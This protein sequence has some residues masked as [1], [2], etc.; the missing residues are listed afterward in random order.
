MLRFC[1][2]FICF[3]FIETLFAQNDTI[4]VTDTVVVD[5]IF[6][7]VDTI[8]TV[9]PQKEIFAFPRKFSAIG[10][11]YSFLISHYY[12]QRIYNGFD[13]SAL[14][15]YTYSQNNL[16][17]QTGL[18]VGLKSYEFNYSFDETVINKSN[19]SQIDSSV[20]YQVIGKDTVSYAATDEHTKTIRDTITN[21]RSATITRQSIYLIVPLKCGI[22]RCRK[23]YMFDV[24][25]GVNSKILF[26]EFANNKSV[27][28]YGKIESLS[29][30]RFLL[31]ALVQ[32]GFG[33]AIVP[34]LFANIS[35]T[36]YLPIITDISNPRYEYLKSI[37]IGIV[38]HVSYLLY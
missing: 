33:Y 28:E 21:H 15:S 4:W 38:L 37:S 7:P 25:L 16:L 1:Y 3:F 27:V 11:E 20:Y 24:F 13:Q 31:D 6:A 14:F 23:Q 30:K 8:Y 22:F 2:L 19:K 10:G 12:P 9:S 26:Y 17:F 18:G 35:A 36:T 29:G 34:H 32:A 5:T